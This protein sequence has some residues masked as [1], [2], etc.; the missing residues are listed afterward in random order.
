MRA[1]T[2]LKGQLE[3]QQQQQQ[4]QVQQQQGTAIRKY[5]ELDG[6]VLQTLL[7]CINTPGT[8]DSERTAVI[9]SQQCTTEGYVGLCLIKAGGWNAN[10]SCFEKPPNWDLLKLD[11]AK[12][13]SEVIECRL[14]E[15]LHMQDIV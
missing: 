1:I 7:N 9:Q 14:R 15:D 13:R 3:G 6:D 12:L 11:I 8:T 10:T 4:P 2:N 5:G